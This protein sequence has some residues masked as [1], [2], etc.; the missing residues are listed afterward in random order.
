MCPPPKRAKASP[1]HKPSRNPLLG[2]C[3]LFVY[4]ISML[5]VSHYSYS[6]VSSPCLAICCPCADVFCCDVLFSSRGPAY[7][8]TASIA[9]PA[10]YFATVSGVTIT[11]SSGASHTLVPATA[12]ADGGFLNVALAIPF[13]VLHSSCCS[14]LARACLSFRAC[15]FAVLVFSLRRVVRQETRK[16]NS[17]CRLG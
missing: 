16:P 17:W 4:C 8:L 7:D 10:V 2:P 3:L 14:G 15:S 13:Q 1:L 5:S 9:V 11:G 6:K 12:P